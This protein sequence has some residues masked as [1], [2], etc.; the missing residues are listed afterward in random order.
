MKLSQLEPS[1]FNPRRYFDAD[2]L[3]DLTEDIRRNG[4]LEP[5]IVRT[6]P[7]PVGAPPGPQ[8]YEIVA[9][10]RRYRALT[11]I[12]EYRNDERMV[13]VFLSNSLVGNDRQSFMV[14]VSENLERQS[15]SPY[16]ET[17]AILQ[18]LHFELRP[19]LSTTA[20]PEALRSLGEFL[21]Q[22]RHR[23]PASREKLAEKHQLTVV[24]VERA[25]ERTF[26]VREGL[27]LK[28]FVSN[29]LPLLK[30]P[31]DL[32]EAL[33]RGDFPYYAARK[34]ARVEDPAKRAELIRLAAEGVPSR[35][36]MAAADQIISPEDSASESDRRLREQ[37]RV[38]SRMLQDMPKLTH[39]QR[40]KLEAAFTRIMEV[41]R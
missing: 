39:N 25:I 11:A 36:L 12:K 30:L 19:A 10:E 20:E 18:V 28:S 37:A 41:L 5:L 32:R 34:V 8:K 13:S 9:G 29:R 2:A 22:W 40:R 6:V 7:K 21:G 4:L 23:K 1:K 31:A 14:A 33:E 35:T 3:A 16:E 15:L 38:V 17:L 27:Q 26:R 24:E